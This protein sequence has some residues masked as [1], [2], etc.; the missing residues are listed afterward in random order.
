MTTT[1][2]KIGICGGT[3]DPFHRGHLDPLL[4]VRDAMQWDRVVYVPARRQPFKADRTAA[5]A[6]HRFA[7]AALATAPFGFVWISPRELERDAISYTVDTLESF[8]AEYADATLDWI[9]GD[10]NVAQLDQ[11]KSFPRILELAN[12]VVLSRGAQAVASTVGGVESRARTKIAV[13]DEPGSRP[14]NGSVVVARN[15]VVPISSTE[16]RKRIRAGEPIDS[17][18]DPRVARYIDHYGLYRAS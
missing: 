15:A 5:S 17:F 11:W 12:F 13:V 1:G 3:F 18:V 4:A 14:A 10:D 7:M 2:M 6:Y 8:R 16:I 9:I